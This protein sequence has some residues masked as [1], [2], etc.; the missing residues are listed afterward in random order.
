MPA[1]IVM[2]AAAIA[3]RIA[4]KKAAQEAA[5]KAAKKLTKKAAKKT[6]NGM[7]AG[8]QKAAAKS[9]RTVDF[10]GKLGTKRGAGMVSNARLVKGKNSKANVTDFKSIDKALSSTGKKSRYITKKEKATRARNKTELKEIRDYYQYS[11]SKPYGAKRVPVKK[12]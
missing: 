5:K 2:G 9:G 4:A 1:P 11:N 6:V 7:T 3:A 12:K 10:N 8:K